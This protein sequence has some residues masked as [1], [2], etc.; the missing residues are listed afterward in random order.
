MRTLLYLN[1]VLSFAVAGCL[2][3]TNG[4]TKLGVTALGFGALNAL[5]FF[6]R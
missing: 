4:D 6:G 5:I 3:I 1:I 2:D